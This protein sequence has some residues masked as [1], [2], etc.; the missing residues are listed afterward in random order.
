MHYNNCLWWKKG[1]G[2]FLLFDCYLVWTHH[3][4]R[5]ECYCMSQAGQVPQKTC[6]DWG[7]LAQGLLGHAVSNNIARQWQG[8]QGF[9]ERECELGCGCN[10]ALGDP[11]GCCDARISLR[12]ALSGG[13]SPGL[14]MLTEMSPW[15]QT[16]PKK[17]HILCKPISL[18]GQFQGRD[19]SGSLSKQF[20]ATV[21]MSASILKQEI[22]IRIQKMYAYQLSNSYCWG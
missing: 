9:V 5:G 16:A 17:G 1:H 19:S 20:S 13:K 18:K 15:I 7:L 12:N 2:R 8:K 6:W 4:R 10:R 21:G 3:I 22:R 14:G 11:T